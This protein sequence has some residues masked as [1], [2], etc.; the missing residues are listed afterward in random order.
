MNCRWQLISK[1]RIPEDGCYPYH[2]ND[3]KIVAA[4]THT[5]WKSPSTQIVF[6]FIIILINTG[7]SP[8]QLITYRIAI[9][10]Q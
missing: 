2:R 7:M 1:L 3:T 9:D 6:W 8:A 4:A 5:I 10:R